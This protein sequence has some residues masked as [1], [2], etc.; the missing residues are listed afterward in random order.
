MAGMA[1]EVGGA[2]PRTNK[3]DALPPTVRVV[4]ADDDP[5][6]LESLRACLPQP[7]I[8]IVGTAGDGEDAVD[9]VERHRPDVAVLDVLMPRLG[10]VEAANRCREA[11]PECRI[12][13]ISGSI[14]A[15]SSPDLALADRF[16]PKSEAMR[17]L[18]ATI[19]ELS[20]R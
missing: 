12:V 9:Q 3:E 18:A 11:L 4:L 16:L 2:A 10:G 1:G 15:E 20:P 5:G 6:F 14:F 17:Q 7:P 8:V 19:L 13:L